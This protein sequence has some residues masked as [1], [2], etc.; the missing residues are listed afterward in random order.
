[1][2]K[3]TNP[4]GSKNLLIVIVLIVAAAAGYGYFKQSSELDDTAQS[5]A[6]SA[7]AGESQTA[8]PTPGPDH[9]I[10]KIRDGDIVTGNAGAPVTVIEYASLSCPHCAHFHNDV[11]PKAK[12]EWADSG[13]A[14]FVYRHFALNEPA[15]RAAQVVECA[16]AAERPAF[17]KTLFENQSKWA[18]DQKFIANLK[19]IAAVGGMDGAAFDSCI[20]DKDIENKILATRMEAA[21]VAGVNSTPTFFVNGVKIE[22]EVSQKALREAIVKAGAK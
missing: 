8:T 17:L 13:K 9:R 6:D 15:L 16:A 4:H 18:F 21:K 12:T 1:M 19:P 3:K 5:I 11:L 2:Y 14:V 20:A 7:V 10:F 22:G